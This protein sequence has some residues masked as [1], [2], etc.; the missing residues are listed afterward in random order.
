MLITN[1]LIR[2]SKLSR[3]EF[4]HYYK[5]DKFDS[6]YKLDNNKL[7]KV[8]NK[9]FWDVDIYITMRLYNDYDLY[10]FRRKNICTRILNLL[11]N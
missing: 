11:K 1:K 6:I 5:L 10:I 8:S 4:I 3:I 9:G 2:I 7:I